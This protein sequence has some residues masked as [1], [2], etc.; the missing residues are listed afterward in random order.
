MDN[1]KLSYFRATRSFLGPN[2]IMNPTGHFEAVD[3]DGYPIYT[4]YDNGFM[5]SNTPETC[6]S[7]YIGGAILGA[8]S[9]IRHQSHDVSTIYLY[10]IETKPDVD[11]SWWT[12]QDFKWLEEVRYR[13]PVQAK[14]VGSYT[15]TPQDR[16][17][18]N[19]LYEL[20]SEDYA[21]N[22]HEERLLIKNTKDIGSYLKQKVLQ[23]THP[24]RLNRTQIKLVNHLK[25]RTHSGINKV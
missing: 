4:K 7:K 6:A 20:L 25:K 17:K 10:K 11:V 15:Y 12:A 23:S 24:V 13:K 21:P 3:A 1:E 18:F 9:M 14:Y 5:I 19:S 22:I 2:P 16:E 8:Y